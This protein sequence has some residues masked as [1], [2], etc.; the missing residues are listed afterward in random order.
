MHSENSDGISKLPTP[1]K[2]LTFPLSHFRFFIFICV[3]TTFSLK[4][5]KAITT[6]NKFYMQH[7]KSQ[8]R[9]IYKKFE[10]CFFVFTK[11]H[12]NLILFRCWGLSIGKFDEFTSLLTLT[13]TILRKKKLPFFYTYHTDFKYC[14]IIWIKFN[15]CHKWNLIILL[16]KGSIVT[17]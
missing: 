12:H 14:K 8:N 10:A 7:W 5:P 16:P 13:F 3:S 17:Q 9:W 2:L 6:L 15:N 1:Y 4:G 11:K